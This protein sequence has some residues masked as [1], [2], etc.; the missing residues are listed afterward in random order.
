MVKASSLIKLIIDRG[1]NAYRC[2]SDQEVT[3]KNCSRIHAQDTQWS[4]MCSTAMPLI[5][6]LDHVI[7]D[8]YHSQRGDECDECDLI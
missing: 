3:V 4:Q 7:R 2:S 1:I 5:F 8:S 6:R